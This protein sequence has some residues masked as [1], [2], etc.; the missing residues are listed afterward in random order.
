VDLQSWLNISGER[1]ATGLLIFARFGGVFLAAPMMSAKV[2]PPP[3]RIGLSAAVAMIL[4]PLSGPAPVESAAGFL[5]GVGKE[6][7]LGL[8]LGW[9]ASLLFASVQMAGEWIDLHSGFQMAQVLN[10]AFDT[11]NALVGHFK[12]LLAGVVF[13]GTGGYAIMIRAAASSLALSPPGALRLN[14]GAAEDWT[15]LIVRI[16]WIALQLAAPAAAALFLA[17]IAMGLMNRALPRLH[18]MMLALPLKALLGIV[19]VAISIPVLVEAL[20]ALFARLGPELMHFLR[21]LG[22]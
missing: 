20:A 1:L 5:I 4:T 18:I 15:G 13:L 16:F 6:V 17:E 10:P 19:A 22:G 8:A 21:I 7:L 3:V 9:I 2:V 12:Y 14:L 11:Q